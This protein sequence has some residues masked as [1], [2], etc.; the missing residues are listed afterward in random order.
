MLDNLVDNAIKYTPEGGQ[1]SI[2][3]STNGI[4]PPSPNGQQPT[5]NSPSPQHAIPS[6]QPT[7]RISIRDSGI[8]IKPEDQ[9]R[10]FERFY[11]VDK[12]RSREL[13]GTGLGLSIVKHLAQSMNG[14]VAV[15]SEVGHGS[16]FTIELPQ[17]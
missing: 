2:T 12:A 6:P 15:S 3:W 13:G 10:I 11:R 17:A 8:G 1:I 16:T 14:T 5:S 4:H 7:I 9:E